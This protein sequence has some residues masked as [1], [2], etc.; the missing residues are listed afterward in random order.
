MG[1]NRRDFLKLAGLSVAGLA[2]TSG[3]ST[4]RAQGHDH[5][6]HGH[7]TP[8]TD[9]P[10]WAMVVD[11]R[12]PCPEDCTACRDA[13]HLAHNVPDWNGSR[14]E[15]K[16]I[17]QEPYEAVFCD[18]VRGVPVRKELLESVMPVL[19]NHCDNPPCVQV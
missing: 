16:W 19:C 18:Q 8:K 7:S 6:A 17:W 12:E 2:A 3:C 9:G 15:V 13:C 11:V 5:G 10:R 1:T 14:H 4:S